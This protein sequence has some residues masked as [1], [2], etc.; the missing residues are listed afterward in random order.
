MHSFM[1]ACG[2]Q[3]YN[4]TAED[5][6]KAIKDAVLPLLLS[7]IP[8]HAAPAGAPAESYL[9]LYLTDAPQA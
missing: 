3:C 6:R 4:E 1:D 9:I 8:Q 5:L 7:A 2:A